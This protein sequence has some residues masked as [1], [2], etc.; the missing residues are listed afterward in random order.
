MKKINYF[1]RLNPPA[2]VISETVDTVKKTFELKRN[3]KV[4]DKDNDLYDI[5]SELVVVDEVDTDKL[6]K[7]FAGQTGL[8]AVLKRVAITGDT[9]LLGGAS[10]DSDE[11][12]DATKIPSSIG[13]VK[14][15]AD[16]LSEYDQLPD[17]IKKGRSVD[18]FIAQFSQTELDAYIKS[19]VDAEIAKLQAK[20]IKEGGSN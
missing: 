15:A 11:I 3:V 5:V 1:T 20:E 12:F 6:T 8:A 17:A 13:E 16:K 4:I 7:S 18:E 14:A 9:S 2:P 19:L 10:Y